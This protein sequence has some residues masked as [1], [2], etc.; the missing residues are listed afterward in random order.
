MYSCKTGNIWVVKTSSKI[1]SFQTAKTKR[2]NRLMQ[3]NVQE[4]G[5]KG[6]VK[7]QTLW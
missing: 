3:K 2:K 7:I 1:Q 4:I 6:P 5:Q